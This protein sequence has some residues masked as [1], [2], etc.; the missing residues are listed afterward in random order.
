MS[1]LPD[2]ARNQQA[3]IR[4]GSNNHE[5]NV[6]ESVTRE[7]I[8]K[9]QRLKDLIAIVLVGGILAIGHD[10]SQENS[11][12]ASAAKLLNTQGTTHLL[13]LE[14]PPITL[15]EYLKDAQ[16]DP[17]R[18]EFNQELPQAI[19][20]KNAAGELYELKPGKVVFIQL[21]S[22]NAEGKNEVAKLQVIAV[23]GD[24]YHGTLNGRPIS[25]NYPQRI[26]GR[27]VD[28][29]DPYFEEPGEYMDVGVDT[30]IGHEK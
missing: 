4:V 20:G 17:A 29:E 25:Y 7:K 16:I 24:V 23:F 8:L 30:I 18:T 14:S 1:L 6:S 22:K 26:Q 2:L 15:E 27:R 21:D 11:V 12:V 9:F 3:S 10:L 28:N 13:H 19:F 5:K